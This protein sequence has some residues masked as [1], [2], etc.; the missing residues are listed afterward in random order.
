MAVFTPAVW[1]TNDAV[2]LSS[3][4]QSTDRASVVNLNRFLAAFATYQSTLQSDYPI[5]SP[6]LVIGSTDTN[7]GSVAFNFNIAT[8][9]VTTKAAVAAG[10]AFGALGTVPTNTWALIAADIVAAGTITFVS[11]AANYTTGYATEAAAIAANPAKTAVKVRMGYI[12]LL[13]KVGSPWIAG[14]DALAGGATGNVASK[15]N[16]YSNA[17]PFDATAWATVNQVANLAGTVLTGL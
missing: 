12:T 15:T 6:G 7:L 5:I 4:Y 14:T 2:R 8:T 10:T 3:T 9:G 11:A 1:P 17:G 13:T 16:Y